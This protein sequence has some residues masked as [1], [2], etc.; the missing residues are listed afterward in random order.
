MEL[1]N[2]LHQK[3]NCVNVAENLQQMV[4]PSIIKLKNILYSS[5]TNQNNIK[6]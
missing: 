6:I 2:Y 4:N 3:H 1:K 5:K